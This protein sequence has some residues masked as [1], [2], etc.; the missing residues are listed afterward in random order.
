MEGPYALAADL[1]IQE[2]RHRQR[3]VTDHLGGQSKPWAMGDE[4][5]VGIAFLQLS[6]CHRV[7]SIGRREHHH[8]MHALHVPLAIDEFNRQPIEQIAIDRNVTANSEVARGRHQAAPEILLPH[9]IHHDAC[10]QWIVLGDNPPGEAEAIAG[11]GLRH[12]REIC[13]HA[14]RDFLALVTEVAA[15]EEM[16]LAHLLFLALLHHER[17]RHGLLE[18]GKLGLQAI[19]F[20]VDR[21]TDRISSLAIM[22]SNGGLLTRGD[23]HLWF[24]VRCAFLGSSSVFA[25]SIASRSRASSLL[26]SIITVLAL[27]LAFTIGSAPTPRNAWMTS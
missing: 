2:S 21:P 14:G 11:R 3:V 15:L 10:R 7:L 8:A 25:T 5:I 23:R 16:R 17:P 12:R 1:F 26:F 19:D 6:R 20:L 13:R 18:L 4:H 22:H 27:A 24:L 9:A